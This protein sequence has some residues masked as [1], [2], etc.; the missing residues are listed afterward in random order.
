MTRTTYLQTNSSHQRAL[1][2][3]S[4]ILALVLAT[5]SKFARAQS[6]LELYGIISNHLVII[7]QSTGAATDIGEIVGFNVFSSLTFDLKTGTMYAVADAFSD[8]GHREHRQG[9]SMIWDCGN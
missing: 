7:D 8:H 9:L 5:G 1:I 6:D 4:I 3:V 2:I